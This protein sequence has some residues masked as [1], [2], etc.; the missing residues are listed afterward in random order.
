MVKEFHSKL[1]SECVFYLKIIFL[2][3][4]SFILEKIIIIFGF[5]FAETVKRDVFFELASH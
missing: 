3:S 2:K 5:I 4:K 1:M